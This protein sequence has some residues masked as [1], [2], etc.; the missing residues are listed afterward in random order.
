[1]ID[2]VQEVF[3][4]IEKKYLLTEKQKNNLLKIIDKNIEKNDYFFSE[5]RNIYFDNSENELIRQS[6]EKPLY[7]EKV[8]IRSYGKPNIEDNIFLEIKKKFNG[9]VYKRRIEVKLKDI[10][11]Y[12]QTG[13]LNCENEQIFKEINYCLKKYNLKPAIFIS[14][15]RYSYLGKEDKNFRIT[16]DTNINYREHN[17]KIEKDDNNVSLIG[18]ENYLMEVKS[19][20]SMPIWF[21]KALSDLKIYPISFSKYGEIYKKEYL[22]NDK[23]VINIETLKENKFVVNI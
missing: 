23:K 11:K 4:R 1:M 13:I 6:I 17:L 14:Y 20:N 21:T 22:N 5:I 15:E 16:F 12:L 7:K 8:R 10:Y 19:L 2:M 3:E 18:K 9:I